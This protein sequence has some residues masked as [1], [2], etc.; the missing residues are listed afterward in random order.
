MTA[1]PNFDTVMLTKGHALCIVKLTDCVPMTAIHE[2]GAKC[3]V[4]PKAWAWILEDVR[5]ITPF[6]VKGKLG[7]FEV[8][9][10]GS[11]NKWRAL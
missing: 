3:A 5:V 11:G 8:M 7:L 4:Y 2:A 1:N 9:I 10:V 6:P